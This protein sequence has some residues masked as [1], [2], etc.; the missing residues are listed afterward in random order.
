MT[1]LAAGVLAAGLAGCTIGQAH[2]ADLDRA[3]TAEDVLPA[4]VERSDDAAFA[5]ESVRL[6]GTF[7]GVDVFLAQGDDEP[8]CLI[9]VQ[10]V[11]KWILSCS[12]GSVGTDQVTA[13]TTSHG[14]PEPGWTL[15]GSNVLI[16]RTPHG[17]PTEPAQ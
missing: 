10:P 5:E 9:L 11:A 15:L 4:F 3:A 16:Q 1:M 14:D 7:E 13:K 17:L 2:Y 8:V 12:G 6:I